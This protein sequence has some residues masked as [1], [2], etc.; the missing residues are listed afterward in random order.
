MDSNVL[1]GAQLALPVQLPDHARFDN[2]VIG[3]G[4]LGERQSQ[5][6][7]HLERLSQENV[8]STL[9]YTAIFGERGRGKT[10]LLCALCE[11]CAERGRTSIYLPL[12]DF[13]GTSAIDILQ[14]LEHY[15]LIALDDVD[16]VSLDPKWAEALFAL[17]NRVQDR[18]SGFLVLSAQGTAASLPMAF[19]DL[20]SRLQWATPFRLGA[21]TDSDKVK[22]LRQHA[23][24]RG[25]ELSEGVAEFMVQRMPRDLHELMNALDRLDSASI[26]KQR[27]LTLPFV[28]EILAL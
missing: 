17:F 10:H 19:E 16:S 18:R 23:Q 21:P 25:L 15:D 7:A 9:Q 1:A 4:N 22:I 3:A 2:F 20:R 27:R 26:E 24:V 6:I 28:K 5:L 13:V 12:R 14:G 11:R 8:Q